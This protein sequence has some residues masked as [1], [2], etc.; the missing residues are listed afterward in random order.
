MDPVF[1]YAR[2]NMRI[3]PMG[4]GHI[5]EDP[6]ME[7]FD[8][9]G[10]GEVVGAGTAQGEE[11]EIEYCGIDINLFNVEQGVP[12]V[13]EFLSDR[14]APKG[15]K[16]QIERDGEQQE[17]PFGEVEGLAIYMNGTDLPDHVYEECDINEVVEELGRLLG[18][19]G[20][21]LDWWE[22]PR[23]TA[24]YLY[25]GSAEEMHGLVADYLA[26]Y[27]LCQKSRVVQIA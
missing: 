1:A 9:N 27:P 19:S 26:S 2:L 15:S 13:C 11:G 25:G 17:I 6:L 24:L 18:D 20:Q 22:G 3:T 7:A 23:D 16:M 12:F 14:G 4:R 5:F 8:E 10:F 21:L